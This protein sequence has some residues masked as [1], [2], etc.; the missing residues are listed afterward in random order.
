MKRA[1]DSTHILLRELGQVYR[2]VI[3]SCQ[4]N[5]RM[6]GAL[7]GNILHCYTDDY[8]LIYSYMCIVYA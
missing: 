8:D 2:P 7:E 3:T 1:I 6:Y 5:G 4:L